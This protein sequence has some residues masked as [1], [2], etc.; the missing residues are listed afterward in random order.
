[1]Q[2]D[3]RNPQGKT[4]RVVQQRQSLTYPVTAKQ[5]WDGTEE[6]HKALNSSSEISKTWTLLQF[7]SDIQQMG[8]IVTNFRDILST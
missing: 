1:M 8:G 7:L 5:E 3:L 6:L 2:V 4:R